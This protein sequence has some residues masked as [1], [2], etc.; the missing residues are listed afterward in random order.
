VQQPGGAVLER[1]FARWEPQ[2]ALRCST[3][4]PDDLRLAGQ[5]CPHPLLERVNDVGAARRSY[6]GG[7]ADCTDLTTVVREIPNRDTIRSFGIPSAASRLINA[8]P[9]AAAAGEAD[10]ET[11]T[12]SF[13]GRTK[14]SLFDRTRHRLE[15]TA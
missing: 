3:R 9:S 8:L 13:L 10:S 6:F 5:Q 7:A 14:C 1:D 15:N 2:I 12:R 11:G 4:F